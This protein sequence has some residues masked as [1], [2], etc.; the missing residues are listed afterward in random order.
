MSLARLLDK[1]VVVMQRELLSTLRMR[2]G[3]LFEVLLMVAE[4]AGFYFLARA[5]GP[6]FRP[7]GVDY[8]RFA[9]IGTAL[10]GLLVTGTSGFVSS[11]HGAQISGA[12]EYLMITATPGPVVI[13]LFGLM[14]FLERAIRI[15][16]LFAF[17]ALL[18]GFR[19]PHAN[20][21]A[22]CVI[23]ALSVLV[24]VAVGLLAA[25][26]QIAIQ[27][28]SMITWV[29]GAAVGV[30]SGAIFP[31]SA[32]PGWLQRL[33]IIIPV[34]Q[35]L[36]G[37]R[38]A[39]LRGVSLA[40]LHTEMLVLGAYALVLLPLSIFALQTTLRRARQAGSLGLY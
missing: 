9:L 19:L 1:I 18:F 30:L 15:A 36:N 12:L 39:L 21:G 31:V 5:I 4:V 11:I 33:A 23:Y 34:T 7:D 26:A 40:S 8:F 22:F 3:F 20:F 10:M 27:R 6:Q 29:A 32:L 2:F 28:G 37:I 13:A 24:A 17:A 38:A 14:T 16:V 25:A 35:S